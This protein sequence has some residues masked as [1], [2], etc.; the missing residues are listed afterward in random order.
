MIHKMSSMLFMIS[1]ILYYVPKF[2]KLKCFASCVKAHIVLGTISISCMIIEF[3]TKIGQPEA[4]KYLGFELIMTGIGVTG[5]LL[6]KVRLSK[7]YRRAHLYLTMGFF[8]Y[9]F[10]SIKYL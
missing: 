2:L 6:K 10:I 1:V 8:V 9:L 7:L 5:Y 4:F 3:I